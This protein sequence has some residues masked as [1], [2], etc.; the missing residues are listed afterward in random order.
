MNKTKIH[1]NSSTEF[2]PQKLFTYIDK[3][4]QVQR[5]VECK[6]NED[7]YDTISI[8]FDGEEHKLKIIA[9]NKTKQV[10]SYRGMCQFPLL[11][12]GEPASFPKNIDLT[13]QHSQSLTGNLPNQKTLSRF[14]LTLD[15]ALNYGYPD[16]FQLKSSIKLL[17]VDDPE[18]KNF[19]INYLTKFGSRISLKEKIS[20]ILCRES[21]LSTNI[22]G[23]LEVNGWISDPEEII[24]LHPIPFVKF[25]GSVF[26]EWTPEQIKKYHKKYLSTF[27][28]K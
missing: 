28:L 6:R 26:A 4:G 27:R 13:I 18:T 15:T 2:E 25:I 3:N 5:S 20:N 17:H 8:K 14:S 11:F 1:R 24:I 22:L 19:L 16:V 21:Q 12:R 7:F 23:L 9:F 10:Q